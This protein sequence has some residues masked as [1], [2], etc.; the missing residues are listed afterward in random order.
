MLLLQIISLNKAPTHEA[1]R[2]RPTPCECRNRKP[3][4]EARPQC[5]LLLA[6]GTKGSTEVGRPGQEM[7]HYFYDIFSVHIVFL[8]LC[9][10]PGI[11]PSEEVGGWD[12]VLECLPGMRPWGQ[13]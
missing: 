7:L 13:S 9:Q 2:P 6:I 12:S 4:V 1:I 8:A 11:K 5:G 10:V 3:E